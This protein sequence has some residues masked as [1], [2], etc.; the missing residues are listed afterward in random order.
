[1]IG[2]VTAKSGEVKELVQPG[3]QTGTASGV[4]EGKKEVLASCKDMNAV[5]ADVLESKKR[6]LSKLGVQKEVAKPKVAEVG[7]LLA[8][9]IEVIKKPEV[10]E[11]AKRPEVEEAVEVK[12]AA[13]LKAE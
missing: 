7:K 6:Y 13:K 5:E 8:E 2:K 10:I 11:V 12:E 4:K 3:K 9:V 1:M